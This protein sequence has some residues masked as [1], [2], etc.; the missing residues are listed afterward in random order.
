VGYLRLKKAYTKSMIEG[1]QWVERNKKHLML[2]NIPNEIFF[3]DKYLTS[4]DFLDCKDKIIHAYQND[5]IFKN[6]MYM[7]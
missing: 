6:A 2:L 1:K 3:W 7:G 4:Y 5:E